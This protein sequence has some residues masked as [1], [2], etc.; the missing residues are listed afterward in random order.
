[1]IYVVKKIQLLRQKAACYQEKG[2]HLFGA[3]LLEMI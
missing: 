2:E 3:G 1:V